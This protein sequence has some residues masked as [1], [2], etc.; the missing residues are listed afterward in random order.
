[1][2]TMDPTAPKTTQYASVLGGQ[3]L[4]E[5]ATVLRGSLE[6]FPNS[7]AKA[8]SE[9]ECAGQTRAEARTWKIA[10]EIP[11][12]SVLADWDFHTLGL[13]AFWLCSYSASCSTATSL[14][15]S[16]ADPGPLPPHT[17]P[18]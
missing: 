4:F 10:V 14:R 1:M 2:S 13:A 8:A 6:K 18:R 11:A 15:C 9:L 3:R 12:V 17:P 7:I 5:I 16:L